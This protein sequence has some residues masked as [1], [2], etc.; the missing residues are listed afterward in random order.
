M[1]IAGLPLLGF[2]LSFEAGWLAGAAG[3]WA[4]DVLPR[5]GAEEV[6]GPP[7]G[8]GFAL[9]HY[10]T[11]PWYLFPRPAPDGKVRRGVCPHCGELRPWRAP[12]LELA[13]IAAFLLAWWRFGGDALQVLVLW[14]FAFYLL[15]VLVI[16]FEHRRVL[17]VMLIPAAALALLASFLLGP[18][19]PVN[20]LLGGALG[21]GIFF[22]I[23]LLGRG[24]MG[25]GDVKLAGVIG[26][27]VGFPAVLQA[28]VIGILLGGAAA[29][30]LLVTRRAGRKSY[31]AYAPYL[32]V[33]ALACLFQLVPPR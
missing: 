23:A 3:N 13:A 30:L 20:A 26:L 12:L 11:L 10:L 1:E 8:Q 19:S 2:V 5:R 29:L 15:V 31:I 4:A 28:L 24:K 27:M 6:P 18:P 33:G 17:N 14:A 22:L 7:V 32:C 25:A 21:L 9:S 16:D